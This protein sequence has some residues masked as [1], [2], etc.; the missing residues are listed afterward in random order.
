[1]FDAAERAEAEAV[2]DA[3]SVAALLDVRRHTRRAVW[4]IASRIIPGTSED[5]ALA[6]AA[7]V[8]REHGLRKGWHK[9]IVRCGA[10]T[11]KNFADPS[12]PGVV[13]AD[14]DIF[15]IDIGPV[16]DG[17]EGDG[18]ATF[19]LGD[20]LDHRRGARDVETLWKVVRDRWRAESASGRQLFAFAQEQAAAMGWQLNLNLSGHRLSDFPHKALFNGKLRDVAFAPS[21]GLW[22][23]EVQIRH[24]ERDFGAFFEDLL[25]ED[26]ALQAEA[27]A[28]ASGL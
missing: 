11:I 17:I 9:I 10:N 12:A 6:V 13:L 25:L 28:P 20:D 5:E 8:L 22:V 18:G 16:C 15:F 7:E 3:F 19:A 2:G 24:P 21:D 14:N 27:F 1:M 26:D 23:L 4:E